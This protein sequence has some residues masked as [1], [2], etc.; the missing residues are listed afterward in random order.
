MEHV[1][2]QILT[3]QTQCTKFI[4]SF[5]CK[6]SKMISGFSAVYNDDPRMRDDFEAC[7]AYLI[8]MDPVAGN[9]L[10]SGS[11]KIIGGVVA[12]VSFDTK[13]NN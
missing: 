3:E 13:L 5:D 6:Y 10:K 11:K 9:Q 4:E 12:M 8:P 7:V 2:H 1:Q